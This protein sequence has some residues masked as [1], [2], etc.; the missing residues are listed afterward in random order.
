MLRTVRVNTQP[1]WTSVRFRVRA[2]SPLAEAEASPVVAAGVVVAAG[3]A[4]Y[5]PL[6]EA[7]GPFAAAVARTEVPGAVSPVRDRATALPL[8]VGRYGDL[9]AVDGDRR[10]FRV[11]LTP[12]G[13]TSFAAMAEQHEQWIVEAFADL[14]AR[15]VDQLHRLLGRLK[16]SQI[17]INR[18]LQADELE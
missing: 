7:I 11:R 1:V 13:Q 17:E 10:A 9:V 4:A 16:Q 18:R 6:L 2:N 12:A 15:D 14:P 8:A 5:L 3:G